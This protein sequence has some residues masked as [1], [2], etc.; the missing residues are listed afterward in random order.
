MTQKKRSSASGSRW[1]WI[2]AG[3]GVLA[4]VAA[5][6]FLPLQDWLEALKE[7]VDG[8]GVFGAILFGA[9]YI[10]ASLLF[11]PATILTI[12]TGYLFGLAGG[13][14]V[15][16]PASTVTAVLAFLIARHFAGARVERLARRHPKFAALERAIGKG[17]WK[18]VVL[19]RWSPI[20]PFSVSNYLYG[21]TPVRFVRYV[22]ASA[23]G[24]LP[25]SFLHVYLGAAGKRLGGN[26]EHSPWEWAMLG[27]GLV[28]TV[29]VTVYVTRLAKKQLQRRSASS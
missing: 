11:V 13:M 17:D 16:W 10:A 18:V 29:A 27:A 19:L 20:V 23:L 6:R 24:I 8:R 22:M 1:K 12:G 14:A 28:A 25:G 9:V 15:V 21:L 4:L 5:W 26:S 7:W 2:A 3:V